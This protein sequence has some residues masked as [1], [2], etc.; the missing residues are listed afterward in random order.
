MYVTPKIAKRIFIFLLAV[1]F[2]SPVP[3]YA[4][5]GRGRAVVRKNVARLSVHRTPELKQSIYRLVRTPVP[6]Y[7][8]F[9]AR[10]NRKILTETGVAQLNIHDILFVHASIYPQDRARFV[11][12]AID[13]LHRTEQRTED[14]IL[15]ARY[16]AGWEDMASPE[17]M[18]L[19]ESGLV[20]YLLEAEDNVV[21]PTSDQMAYALNYYEN[22]L[23]SSNYDFEQKMSAVTN[24]GL[25]G[26]VSHA[27]VLMRVAQTDFGILTP[28]V[29]D[30]VTRALLN[31]GAYN[32]LKTLAQ[33]RVEEAEHKGE[34]LP[35]VWRGIITVAQE[36]GHRLS[37]RPG[38][39]A[40][41]DMDIP[42]V[43]QR[44]L[45]THHAFNYLLGNGS[46]EVTQNWQALRAGLDELFA[47]AD[48][49]QGIEIEP[50]VKNMPQ[51][52]AMETEDIAEDVPSGDTPEDISLPARNEDLS[53]AEPDEN[54]E[55][56]EISP[57]ILAPKP[58]TPRV[59]KTQKSTRV[60][61]VAKRSRPKKVE[62][63]ELL[64]ITAMRR[65]AKQEPKTRVY[66]YDLVRE[67]LE[68]YVQDHGGGLPHSGTS[69]RK[70]ANYARQK[71]DP[72]DPDVQAI[73]A[74][75]AAHIQKRR[76][77]PHSVREELE[78]YIQQHGSL[79]VSNTPLR[80][81][82]E[83]V[84]TTGDPND[85]DVQAVL[86][87]F[88]EHAL[89]VKR[90]FQSVREELESY[91][92]E[93]DGNYPPYS[94]ALGTAVRRLLGKNHSDE[95]PDVAA[96]RE[97]WNGRPV[98][99]RQTPLTSHQLRVALETYMEQHN[100]E[101]PYQHHPIRATAE[102]RLGLIWGEPKDPDLLIIRNIL[103]AKKAPY[104]KRTPGQVRQELETY[105]QK[106]DNQMPPSHS[107][108]NQ[109]V[110]RILKN[111]PD[112]PDAL[113]IRQIVEQ[114]PRPK[115]VI[116]PARSPK[117]V[118]AE[119]KDYLTTHTYSPHGGALYQA[120]HKII[121]RGDLNDPDVQ[122]VIELWHAR[123]V[124][125]ARSPEQVYQELYEFW[126]QG[127]RTLPSVNPVYYAARSLLQK[128]NPEDPYIKAI[129]ELWTK[130]NLKIPAAK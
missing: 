29:D 86:K 54:A 17:R 30:F 51:E 68:R 67:E 129:L 4:Q 60:G 99:S 10:T 108:L 49:A 126:Q 45:L 85:P 107:R 103:V 11:P 71:G 101:I 23:T 73:S 81:R 13:V 90:D 72:N 33:L 93:H 119:L 57:T 38:A 40:K 24:L 12:Q 75:L 121:Q 94:S 22:V 102:Y 63:P 96:I 110:K 35:A 43:L 70:R 25:L 82:A 128:G 105:L 74:L 2:F 89:Q 130:F 53:A 15:N 104:T 84:K 120:V 28:L 26:N 66:H 127:N 46:L 124:K 69:L 44:R 112:N 109:A 65:P 87:L 58:A 16:A 92:R 42:E 80:R 91:L 78:M 31:I 125:V 76:R 37:I 9:F 98:K 111:Y 5:R 115:I 56:L 97:L 123:R 20:T 113:I 7:G 118:L 79:P 52:I 116:P 62:K 95:N 41:Q 48:E 3:G 47:Q 100:G 34:L 21:L 117:Q 106:H 61:R 55:D 1:L 32:E 77:T 114:H 19:L 18:A 50:T 14:L 8:P 59:K 83:Q 36:Q 39:I 6:G 88:E 64:P 122:A 27:P